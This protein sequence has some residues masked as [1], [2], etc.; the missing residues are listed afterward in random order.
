MSDMSHALIVASALPLPSQ[1]ALVAVLRRMGL[2]PREADSGNGPS[3]RVRFGAV[4][5]LLRRAGPDELIQADPGDPTT[6]S[7]ATTLPAA[8]RDAGTC[9]NLV[10]EGDLA[11]DGATLDDAFKMIVLLIDLFDA[12]HFFWS[13]ARLWSD[14]P[15]L[16]ASIAEMQASGMPPVLHLVAFR[17]RG[18]DAGERMRT[19]G[20]S[21]FT[22]QELEAAVPAGW[23]VAD[24]VKRLARLAIDAMLNGPVVREQAAPGLHAGERVRLMPPDP[25]DRAAIVKVAFDRGG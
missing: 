9:W 1:E 14:A 3:A 5:A 22:G 15:Q 7:L 21:L 10:F 11:R 25:E 13:A 16:R 12:S 20:L 2:D 23:T 24:M 6:S 17:R 19:R 18:E 4:T 8:W